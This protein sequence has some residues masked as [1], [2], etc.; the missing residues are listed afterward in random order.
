MTRTRSYS[1][2]VRTE[3]ARHFAARI[4]CAADR[5]RREAAMAY[6]A[7]GELKVSEVADMLG[8]HRATIARQAKAM[9]IDPRK[10]RA[11]LLA[12]LAKVAHLFAPLFD[13]M[14]RDRL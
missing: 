3:R 7:A 14:M 9:G 8:L 5:R 10:A 12:R 2:A 13:Q 4:A 6:L 11:G 1:N